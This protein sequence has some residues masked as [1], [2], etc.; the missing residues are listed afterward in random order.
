MI[1]VHRTKEFQEDQIEL[2]RLLAPHLQRAMA[3]SLKLRRLEAERGGLAEI[4]DHLDDGV[5]LLD[6]QARP[7]FANKAAEPLFAPGRPFRI[8]SGRMLALRTADTVRSHQLVASC[9]G[10]AIANEAGGQIFLPGLNGGAAL[11]TVVIPTRLKS[12]LASSIP[13]G[14]DARCKIYASALFA[15]PGRASG[16]VRSDS[17]GSG[18]RRRDLHR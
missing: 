18:P 1:G 6:A 10:E 8:A 5:I 17:C 7:L 12:V 16:P 11:A 13:A 15:A 3:I 9:A 4:L 14:C 2:C